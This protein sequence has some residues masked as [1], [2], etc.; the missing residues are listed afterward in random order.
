MSDLPGSSG[1]VPKHVRDGSGLTPGRIIGAMLQA[2]SQHRQM[3]Q[4]F[5]KDFHLRPNEMNLRILS[6]LN[7]QLATRS[8]TTLP[9]AA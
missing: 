8:V 6:E 1:I 2:H 3:K 7:H 5:G 9:A 4:S